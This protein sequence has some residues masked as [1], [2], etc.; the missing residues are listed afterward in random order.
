MSCYDAFS[1]E[2][3]ISV[4]SRHVHFGKITTDLHNFPGLSLIS[5][6]LSQSWPSSQYF[7]PCLEDKSGVLHEYQVSILASTNRPLFRH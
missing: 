6:F 7:L 1:I 5:L 4:F 2:F 3:K